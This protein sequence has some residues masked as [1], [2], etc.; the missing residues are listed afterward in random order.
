LE[1]STGE[2][3]SFLELLI[4]ELSHGDTSRDSN[5]GPALRNPPLQGTTSEHACTELPEPPV[6]SS[7]PVT[8]PT[9]LEPVIMRSTSDV[10]TPE[11]IK[12]S[13]S[14]AGSDE[15]VCAAVHSAR[16]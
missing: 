3:I 5:D 13:L 12:R 8:P 4:K 11:R 7:L 10:D 16:R 14:E 15:E 9:S 6:F 2:L 1:Q